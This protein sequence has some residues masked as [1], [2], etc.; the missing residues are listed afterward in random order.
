LFLQKNKSFHG[1]WVTELHKLVHCIRE[2]NW[3][4]RNKNRR[5]LDCVVE[6]WVSGSGF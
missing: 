4:R 2:G 5:Y 3:S 6:E 1:K